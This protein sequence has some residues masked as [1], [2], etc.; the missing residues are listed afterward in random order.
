MYI[1][2]VKHISYS[3]VTLLNRENRHIYIK[4]KKDQCIG[5]SERQEPLK[6]KDIIAERA[7]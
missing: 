4:R 1:L 2:D 3:H 5:R 6:Q 7:K